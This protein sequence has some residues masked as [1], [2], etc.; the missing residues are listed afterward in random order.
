MKD[1]DWW[2]KEFKINH[3][4]FMND[5]ELLGNSHGQILKTLDGVWSKKA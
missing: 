5:F 3:L 2:K 4:L 1:H